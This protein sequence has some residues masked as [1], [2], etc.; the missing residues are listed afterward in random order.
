MTC[1][2]FCTRQYVRI[3]CDVHAPI[4]LV[5]PLQPHSPL[6][7]DRTRNCQLSVVSGSR[8]QTPKKERPSEESLKEFDCFAKSFMH[9]GHQHFKLLN[10]YAVGED[11]NDIVHTTFKGG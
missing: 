2:I 6:Q 1:P 10:R 9:E 5:Q 4:Y 11:R 3:I 8:N 7:L